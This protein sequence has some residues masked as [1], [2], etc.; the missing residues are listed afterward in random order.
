M[1]KENF[2]F[3]Q[4]EQYSKVLQQ[5]LGAVLH[6]LKEN[7]SVSTPVKIAFQAVREMLELQSEA[8]EHLQDQMTKKA[9]KA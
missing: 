9:S 4:P 3:Q 2:S 5:K 7:S 6:T 1:N 8:L